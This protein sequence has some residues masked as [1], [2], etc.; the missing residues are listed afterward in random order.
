ML[1]LYIG[2][3]IVSEAAA[4]AA[5]KSYTLSRAPWQFAL[6]A[7][8]YVL[9]AFLLT[10]TFAYEEIGVVNVLWSVLSILIVTSVGYLAFHETLGWR[11]AAG[12]GLA[13][14][15]IALIHIG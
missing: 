4:F 5:L 13:V 12:M 10:R 8:M 14:I 11:E 3:I 9:I 2:L 7:A 6:G 1:Y 15:G